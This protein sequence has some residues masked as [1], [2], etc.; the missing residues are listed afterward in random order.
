MLVAVPAGKR[1]G[2]EFH[3]TIPGALSNA[4][5]KAIIRRISRVFRWIR[6][7]FSGFS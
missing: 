1:V 3:V 7:G 5:R 6:K 2:E 4:T